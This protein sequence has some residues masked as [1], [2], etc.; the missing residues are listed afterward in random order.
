MISGSS[1]KPRTSA[2]GGRP[3][4][5]MAGLLGEKERKEGKGSRGSPKGGESNDRDMTCYNC[6][7]AAG[8]QIV[9]VKN[10]DDSQVFKDRKGKKGASKGSNEARQEKEQEK[11]ASALNEAGQEE[12]AEYKRVTNSKKKMLTLIEI[13]GFIMNRTA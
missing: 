1:V 12:D 13:N 10:K 8:L 4:R 6:A 2:H 9:E 3:L 7:K 11:H 5:S